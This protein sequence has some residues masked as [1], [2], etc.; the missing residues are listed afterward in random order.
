MNCWRT[1]PVKSLAQVL[2]PVTV[3]GLLLAISCGALLFVTRPE[4]YVYS[5]LFIVKMVL[6]LLGLVNAVALMLSNAWVRALATDQLSLRLK[7]HSA[8]S[9][10]V[11]VSIVLIGRLIGYR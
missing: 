4:D 3:M 5:T 8:V 10:L 1:V 7:L 6:L 11:W 9:L 2:I